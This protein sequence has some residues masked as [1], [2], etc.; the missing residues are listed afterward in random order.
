MRY[1][2]TIEFDLFYYLIFR[3][4]MRKFEPEAMRAFVK[5]KPLKKLIAQCVTTP[6]DNDEKSPEE[7]PVI[8]K[9]ELSDVECDVI[10]MTR[11]IF[12]NIIFEIQ[13]CGN[14]D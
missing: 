2:K 13:F 5:Y 3:E 4:E 14:S 1:G 10:A 8:T 7:S 11:Y 12:D 6:R 9:D